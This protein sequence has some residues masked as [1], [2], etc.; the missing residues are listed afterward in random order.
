M[1]GRPS[2]I[3]R[4]MCERG[5]MPDEVRYACALYFGGTRAPKAMRE[6]IRNFKCDGTSGPKREAI[7]GR[8]G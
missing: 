1:Q 4:I 2:S 7:H 5:L 3:G 8:L 6:R